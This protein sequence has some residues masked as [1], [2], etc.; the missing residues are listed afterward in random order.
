MMKITMINL[1]LWIPF[2][3]TA[4]EPDFSKE[5]ELGTDNDKFIAYTETDRNYTYGINAALRWRGNEDA[6]LGRLFP[7][8]LGNYMGIGLN[9]KAFTP[10]YL[11]EPS[12]EN[13][14]TERPFAG[15]SYIT[16]EATY[17]FQ[18]S[19]L[20]M[21][22]ETGILGPDSQAER[23]Q[24]WFHESISN[25]AFVNWDGQ[26][27]NQLGLNI[28]SSYAQKIYG[29]SWID[30]YARADASIGT[31]FTYLRPQFNIRIGKFNGIG[32]SIATQNGLLA[33]TEHPEFFLEYGL[34]WKL[35]AYNATV[36]GNMFRND[37]RTVKEINNTV[38][39]MHLG[40]NLS[41]K[42]LSVLF[43]YQYGTGEFE[44]TQEHRYG[45]LRLLYRFK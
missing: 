38:F 41:Y 43:K 45:A 28:T 37:D 4:Q 9:L 25:D 7:N 31:I 5:L 24:N 27:P 3:M 1:I 30:T 11:D 19:F 2:L 12:L 16:F 29:F 36:Q 13:P 26:I 18:H 35:S 21:G 15:W 44:R 23:V 20:R 39:M 10:N 40:L 17:A 42:R 14:S 32:E 6:L 34:G 33:S 22:V 8:K